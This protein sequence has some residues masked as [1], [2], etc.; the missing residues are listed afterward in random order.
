MLLHLSSWT[1]LSFCMKCENWIEVHFFLPNDV[2][3]L[4]YHLLK[5][6]SSPALNCFCIF[7][8]NLFSIFVWALCSIPLICT[9]IP[10]PG[11][12]SLLLYCSYIINIEIRWTDS[13][14]FI[15]F[16][17]LFLTEV[18]LIYNI[19]LISN[20]QYSDSVF[21]RLYSI[22]SLYK[23]MVIIP[24]DVQCTPVDYLFYTWWWWFSH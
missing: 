18:E 17:S 22:K 13:F 23:L 10:P 14:H 19:I 2:Q 20:I 16:S 12:H 24:C 15:L 8:N 5:R 3:L 7:V 21:Y 4:Y 1:I 11:L 9:C 6:L